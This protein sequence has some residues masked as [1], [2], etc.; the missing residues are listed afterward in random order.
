VPNA[1]WDVISVDFIVELPKSH[2]YDAIMVM[3]YSV[4]KMSH[5]IETNTTIMALGAA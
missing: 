4:S 2:G 3:V 1:R 5:F